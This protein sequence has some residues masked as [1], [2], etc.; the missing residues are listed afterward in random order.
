MTLSL[1]RNL[2]G[3]T[4]AHCAHGP[5]LAATLR[6]VGLGSGSLSKKQGA[7]WRGAAFDWLSWS[8]R[9]LP[10]SHMNSTGTP[11]GA[12]RRTPL[13][14]AFQ[15]AILAPASNQRRKADGRAFYR[16]P[17]AT[18]VLEGKKSWTESSA[19]A[20]E[21]KLSQQGVLQLL[22][23]LEPRGPGAR[24]FHRSLFLLQKGKS[25]SS[26]SPDVPRSRKL[27]K[28]F[29]FFKTLM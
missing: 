18:T 24:Q 15:A 7:S 20:G 5:V 13:G 14:G 3:G 9:G 22:V 4:G 8:R 26:S 25:R 17:P 21:F 10:T 16:I 29:V 12:N 11:R 2:A 27:T 23:P 28:R 1:R 19:V 6:L